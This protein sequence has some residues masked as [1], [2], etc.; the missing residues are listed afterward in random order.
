MR[1]RAGNVRK[2]WTWILRKSTAVKG[3]RTGLLC[4]RIRLVNIRKG[5][6]KT[7]DFDYDL[8]QE[9]IAQRPADRRENSRLMVLDRGRGSIEHMHFYDVVDHLEK[10]D[11]L[12]VNDSKVLPARLKGKKEPTGANVE[13]LL[14]KNLQGDVWES[15]VRPGKRLKPGDKVDF[16]SGLFAEIIDY[17][18]GGTRK[19]RFRYEGE[20]FPLLEKVG[21]VPLPPYI[22]R[23]SD[24]DDKERYQTVY[25]RKEGSVAAPTAGLHFTK[26][27]MEKA[28]AKGVSIVR[29]EL[30]VGIGTFRPVSAENIEEHHM[31][32][33]E[34]FVSED[35][36]K[37][38]NE[39]KKNGGR[40][41]AVGTTSVRTLESAAHIV[42]DGGAGKAISET[43]AIADEVY[44]LRPGRGETDIFIYPGYRFKLVDGLI[45]NFHLPRSTL[46]MLVSAFY[47]KDKI[48]EA[49]REAVD[50][51]YRFFSYGDAMLI[52]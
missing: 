18:D 28:E 22:E 6:M 9:L 17:M 20:F 50:K 48:L 7:K 21:L 26:E 33:E 36:A 16:G 38:I 46:L 14:V 41:I 32:L 5:S 11:C 24:T 42:N 15:M 34:Y 49:Y 43:G 29:V 44:E 52:K 23:D 47:S 40:V 30:H 35:A 3:W 31:H 51:G 8:P 4:G 10:G 2:A 45:T 1:K 19:V 37:K 27:I 13:F 25:A 12:V 39:T